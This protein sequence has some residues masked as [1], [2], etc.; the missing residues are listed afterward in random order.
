ML[1]YDVDQQYVIEKR[2]GSHHTY[3]NWKASFDECKA[4]GATGAKSQMNAL[5]CSIE[6][7]NGAGDCRKSNLIGGTL[8]PAYKVSGDEIK[9]T[10][11]KG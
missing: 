7:C 4:P 11:C 3:F 6:Q 9:T 2:L 1:R 10:P 8:C 5:M